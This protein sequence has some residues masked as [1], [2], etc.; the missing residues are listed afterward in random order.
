MHAVCGL[1][2]TRTPPPPPVRAT[3]T[4]CARGATGR[5]TQLSIVSTII[6]PVFTNFDRFLTSIPP[7]RASR[8][9]PRRPPSLLGRKRL[10]R[11]ATQ[12]TGWVGARVRVCVCGQA[13][14][15]AC[16]RA[17]SRVADPSARPGRP[18]G[19]APARPARRT[20]PARHKYWST[21]QICRPVKCSG[22]ASARPPP[23]LTS[24]PGFDQYRA[25]AS[26]AAGRIERLTRAG[27]WGGSPAPSHVPAE[28][29]GPGPRVGSPGRQARLGSVMA[30]VRRR[31]TPGPRP[32]RP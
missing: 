8:P 20:T 16:G 17:R 11:L 6:L 1:Y 10:S 18:A 26:G 14:M 22:A 27:P 12:P 25:P 19:Q 15:R 2:L 21:G 24:W 31:R 7:Q 9:G 30:P 4:S 29:S 28:P 5:L 3:A 13:R 23:Y 32:G